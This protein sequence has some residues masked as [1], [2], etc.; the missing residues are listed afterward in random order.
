MATRSGQLGLPFPDKN[1]QRRRIGRKAGRTPRQVRH[2]L[3]YVLN[4]WRKHRE[5]RAA[6]ARAWN[7]DPF[8]TGAL[9]TGWKE[10][11]E[12]AVMWRWRASYDPLVVYRP[13]TW[14]L[15][16]GWRRHGLISFAEVPN[17]R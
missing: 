15:R 11:A 6:V 5:D 9:F 7:V 13:R 1:G 12:Q 14:L 10:H 3:S 2:A 16:E 8:S 4:N 17:P